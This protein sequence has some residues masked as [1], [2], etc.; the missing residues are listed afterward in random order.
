MFADY[1]VPQI[2]LHFKVLD[3]S[4]SLLTKI[5]TKQE[6][7]FGSEEETEIRAGYKY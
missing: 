5:E 6:I 2:L 4:Q 3:Y 7:L 1:R